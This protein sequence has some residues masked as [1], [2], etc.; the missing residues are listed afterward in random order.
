MT[1][2][3]HSVDATVVD[4]DDESVPLLLGPNKAAPDF[5]GISRDIQNRASRCIR[6][7]K[8]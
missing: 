7:E 1:T 2:D 4:Y 3:D 8:T 5:E 6:S